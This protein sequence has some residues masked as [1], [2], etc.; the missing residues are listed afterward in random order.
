MEHEQT[1]VKKGGKASQRPDVKSGPVL[2]NTNTPQSPQM[3][4]Y[5]NLGNQAVQRMMESGAIQAKLKIGQPNDKYEQEADRVA[6]QVMRM[7]EPKESLVNGHSSLVQR[8]ST[9][10]ECMEEDELIQTKGDEGSTPEVTS[11]MESRIQSLKSGGQPL[12]G[13]TRAFFEPRFGA[14]FNQVRVHTDSIAAETAKSVNAKAFTIGKDVIFGAGQ[15]SPRTST[16]KTLLAHELTHVVQQSKKVDRSSVI[17][18]ELAGTPLSPAQINQAGIAVRSA[19]SRVPQIISAL[20]QMIMPSNWQVGH[21]TECAIMANFNISQNTNGWDNLVS[22]ILA[23]F[24]TINGPLISGLNISPIFP[25]CRLFKAQVIAGTN[26]IH[27]C[28]NF[29]PPAST[30]DGMVATVIHELMHAYTGDVV[31][32]SNYA[33]SAQAGC[34]IR[35]K[36]NLADNRLVYNGDSYEGFV[37]NFL[38]GSGP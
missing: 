16:G 28:P 2:L 29:F 35:V 31:D 26:T 32:L 3:Q 10:P 34:A 20:L 24:N 15:Y 5:R 8:E 25:T 18:L 7:P 4:H 19:R 27:L 1:R 38:Q 6:D 17:Q 30:P 11:G 21:R 14:D 37:L 22:I 13:S 33:G 9:C 12:P 36:H 23:H